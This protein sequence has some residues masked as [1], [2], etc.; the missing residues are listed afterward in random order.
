MRA[1]AAWR[2][3]DGARGVGRRYDETAEGAISELQQM[4]RENRALRAQ[5]EDSAARAEMFERRF[6]DAAARL[7][8]A[9]KGVQRLSLEEGC[10]Q[11]L[12]QVTS[13][14]RPGARARSRGSNAARAANARRAARGAGDAAAG[15]GV[16]GQGGCRAAGASRSGPMQYS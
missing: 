14:A 1:A 16:G 15:G 5:L 10:R 9:E 4:D 3:A 8:E 12:I 11:R 13:L 2:G 6:L 7:G